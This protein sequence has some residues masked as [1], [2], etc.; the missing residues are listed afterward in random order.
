MKRYYRLIVPAIV[1]LILLANS[2]KLMSQPD[3]PPL[4]DQHGY[5]GNKTPQGAPLD[6]G[7]EVLLFLGISYAAKKMSE[8]KRNTITGR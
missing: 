6:G 1:M 2:E 7:S 5:N 3:P 4:P 8:R